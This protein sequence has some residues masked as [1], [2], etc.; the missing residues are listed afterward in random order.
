MK[1]K[2]EMSMVLVIALAAVGCQSK[3]EELAAKELEARRAAAQ[4]KE[5]GRKRLTTNEGFD[6]FK[7]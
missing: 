1:M 3:Q 2:T 7:K 4:K 5:E 6:P